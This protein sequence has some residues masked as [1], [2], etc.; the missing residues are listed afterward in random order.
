MAVW[1]DPTLPSN[2]VR[3]VRGRQRALATASSAVLLFAAQ[4][5]FAQTAPN[6]ATAIDEVVVTGS[7]ISRP[8]YAAN[9]PVVSVT[10]EALENTGQITVE[11]AL[12]QLPQFSG[13]FGQSNTASTGTGLNGG[14][15]YATLRGLGSKRTLLLLDGKRLQPSNPDGSVD[16]NTIPEALIGNVEVITGG[17]STAYGSD[18]TAGVVN[19]RLKRDFSGLTLNTQYGISNYG[20]GDS[21]RYNATGGGRFDEGRGRAIL[22]MDFSRRDRAKRRER[23]WYSD[24]LPQTGNA[25]SYNGSAVF[26]G[27]EPTLAAVNAIFAGKYGLTPFTTTNNSRLFGGGAQ[28]GFNTDGTLFTANGVP[29]KNFKEPQTDDAYLVDSGNTI[30]GPSQQMKFGFTG[31][32]LQTD[33]KRYSAFGRVDYDLTETIEA[34]AQFSYTTY[35]QTAIVNTTLSNNIYL[36]SIPYNNPFLPADLRAILAS[37]ANP[38]ADFQF[39]KAFNAIG[40]RYQGYE[41]DVWQM[42]AGLTGKV[43]IKDWSWEAYAATSSSAFENSQTGGLSLSRVNKLTYS[44]TGGTDICAGGLNLFGNFPISEACAN[45]I[46]R[47]TLN[48]TDMKQRI[49]AATVQGAL[50]DLPAGEVRFAAGASYRYNSFIYD[51]D[52]ALNQPDG[53]SDIIGFAVLRDSEGSVKTK[54]LYG[55]LLVPLLKDI[56]FIQELNLDLGYRFSDYDSIG[57]A[58]T[59]KADVEWSVTDFLRLRGG[60]NRAIRAPSV[61]ELFAPVSTGSVSI[62]NPGANVVSGDPCDVRSSFRLG[63][64]RDKVRALCITQGVTPAIIDGYIGTA[65]VFPLTGG[66]PDLEEETADTWSFGTVVR[67]PFDHPLLSNLTVSVDWYKIDVSDA[68]GVLSVVQSVQYCF[69]VGGSN[70]TYDPKNYYCSLLSR[71]RTGA[72]EA[73]TSQPLLNLAQFNVSGIDVQLDW[74]AELS[75]VGIPVEGRLAFRS[76]VSFLD[77]FEVQALPGAAVYDFAGTIGTS[78]ESNA[79]IAHPE[80]KAITSLTYSRDNGSIGVTW[81]YIDKMKHSNFVTSP[82]TAPPGISAYN[83]F[84]INARYS[85]PWD[86]DVRVGITNLFN[87][88][89]PPYGSTPETYDSSSYD[90][91]GRYFFMSLTK[92]F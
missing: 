54:E 70:P 60:Y 83:A 29:V 64:D 81:R 82:T 79:G 39:H 72:L 40:N 87:K 85:L 30:Y 52:D 92:K 77:K 66:N 2:D 51:S 75:D 43:G 11:S 42:M 21:Y 56:P 7:L 74:K 55:E 32:D 76:A 78:V 33:M 90:V 19:F 46:K 35:K 17:A 9:S 62:G 14:Q 31:G 63:A 22:S 61:G 13:G 8:D 38:T 71:A 5:A 65:Q 86:T 12:T 41:Y 23:P 27:N 25:A 16:L 73:P 84:D 10:T 50:F 36:Q 15:S 89:P 49:A 28:I 24:R 68:I 88:A 18:A 57:G 37:R 20:D 44:P 53:T 69:N 58:H 6:D 67:S 3:S 34:F 91:V 26:A 47:D 45:Y 59:Y 80:F 1:N 48:T 4:S